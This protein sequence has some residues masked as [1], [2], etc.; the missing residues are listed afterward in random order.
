MNN[1]D[2]QHRPQRRSILQSPLKQSMLQSPVSR[3]LREQRNMINE[4][5]R[6]SIER[7]KSI[8]R[9]DSLNESNETN[10]NQNQNQ[11]E[12]SVLKEN[13]LIDPVVDASD[14][15]VKLSKH[16]WIDPRSRFKVSMF[17][18]KFLSDPS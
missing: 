2:D 5:R 11:N 6:R 16:F 14:E 9:A 3:I 12:R 17:K 18:E 7:S 10:N 8:F 4:H 1:D 13:I 15:N